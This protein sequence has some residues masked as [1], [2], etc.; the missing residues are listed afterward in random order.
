M[1]SKASDDIPIILYRLHGCP[2]CERVVRRLQDYDVDYES[3]FVEPNHSARNAVK[4][5]SGVRTV[6]VIIDHNTGVTM[7]ESANILEYLDHNY[8]A[9]NT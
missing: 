9:E 1:V 6:P 7:A 5:I 8:P 4:R 2:W 3:R